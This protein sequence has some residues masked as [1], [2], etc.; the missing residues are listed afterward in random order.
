MK[1]RKLNVVLT[2]SYNPL[3]NVGQFSYVVTDPT[4]TTVLIEYESNIFKTESNLLVEIESLLEALKIIREGKWSLTYVMLDE[5]YCELMDIIEN[6]I[7]AY[8]KSRWKNIENQNHLKY[9][10]KLKELNSLITK[11]GKITFTKY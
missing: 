5:T 8:R 1:V 3:D 9:K 4:N 7:P 11:G 2:N 10:S 6:D